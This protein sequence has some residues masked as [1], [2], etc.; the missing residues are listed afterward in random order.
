MGRIGDRKNE[1]A[2]GIAVIVESRVER[3]PIT[4][5]RAEVNE[6]F[7]LESGQ[8]LLMVGCMFLYCAVTLA[9]SP[10]ASIDNLLF[11]SKSLFMYVSVW[12]SPT[13]RLP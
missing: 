8:S 6:D 4:V 9:L 12:L 10:Q 7:A 13:R 5:P 11:S 1:T 2:G 3:P